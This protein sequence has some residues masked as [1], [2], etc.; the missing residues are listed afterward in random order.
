MNEEDTPRRPMVSPLA[1]EEAEESNGNGNGHEEPRSGRL[2]DLTTHQLFA[3][4]AFRVAKVEGRVDALIT[5]TREARADS[6]QGLAI[7]LENRAEIQEVKAGVFEILGLLRPVE[8]TARSA[9]V[10]STL[11]RK[12]SAISREDA[13]RAIRIAEAARNEANRSSKTEEELVEMGL[14]L[15]RG[16]VTTTLETEKLTV[17]SAGN[18]LVVAHKAKLGGLDLALA[19]GSGVLIPAAAIIAIALAKGCHS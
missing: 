13:K 12:E 19:F 5:D 2:E 3:D 16:R 11:A 15:A 10:E 1:R 9:R 18:D 8:A 6:K 17:Q 14:Q 7:G 4:T